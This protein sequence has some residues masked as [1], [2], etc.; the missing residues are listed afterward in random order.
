MNKDRRAAI[1][2]KK[3][4]EYV[5]CVDQYFGKVNENGKHENVDEAIFHQIMIDVLRTNPDVPFYQNMKVRN[6]IFLKFKISFKK[7]KKSLI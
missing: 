6:V 2:E 4:K 3:R 1:L 7:K 5:E